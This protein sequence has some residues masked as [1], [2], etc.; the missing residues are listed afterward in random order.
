MNHTGNIFQRNHSTCAP[1]CDAAPYCP[2]VFALV[3]RVT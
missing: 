3:E 2:V 1:L